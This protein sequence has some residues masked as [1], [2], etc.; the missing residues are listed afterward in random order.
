MIK[1]TSLNKIYKSKKRKLCHA[2]KD[3]DLTLADTGLVF[4]LG[5]SGSGKSTLL[6]LIGG[7]DNIT[8]GSIDVD[9]NDLS[10]LNEKAFCNYRNTHIGFIFQDYHLIDEMTVYDNIALSLN[11]LRIEAGDKVTRALEKVDLAGYEERFPSEL[12]GGERQRVAIARAIVKEPRIILADEPTG[13]LDT[14]TSKA[15][16]ELLQSI[17]KECLIIVVSH[18]V[19]EAHKYAD[20]IIELSNGRV[21]NDTMRNPDFSDEVTLENGA[22]VYPMDRLLSDEDISLI[23]ENQDKKIIKRS[24]K[25]IPTKICKKS[26]SKR[27]IENKTLSFRAKMS[28]CKKFLANKTAIIA[29]SAFMVSVIIVIMSLAQTVINFKA[30]D[31]LSKEIKK[32]E[33]D[34][35]LFVKGQGVSPTAHL[36]STKY[37]VEIG[38]N[39][40]KTFTDAGYGGKIYPVYNITVPVTSYRNRSGLVSNNI[41]QN[42]LINETLGTM[43]VTEEFLKDKFGE[44]KYI[45]KRNI[46]DPAGLIITD[47]VA[48]SI[49]S[50]HS[51]YKNKTY[52]NILGN[53]TYSGLNTA[54]LKINAIID[55]GYDERYSVLLD[56]IKNNEFTD[57]AQMYQ[58]R[59][60]VNFSNEIYDRLGFS[61]SLNENFTESFINNATVYRTASMQKLMV[62]DLLQY[63]VN[64]NNILLIARGTFTP[65]T[66]SSSRYYTDTIPD[67]PANAKYMTVSFSFST[68]TKK[69]EA[70]LESILAKKECAHIVFSNGY[71]V[72]KERLNFFEDRYLTTKGT[73]SDTGVTGTSYVS[74]F[75][76][77]PDGAYISEFCTISMRNNAHCAFYDANKKLISSFEAGKEPLPDNSISMNYNHYNDMFGT[78]YDTSSLDDFIPHKIKLTQYRLY[79]TECKYPMYSVEVTITAL[80]TGITAV[81]DNV[82]EEFAKNDVYATALYMDEEGDL[83]KVFALAESMN[84]ENQSTSIKAI[85]TMTTAVDVFVPIFRLIAIVL[86][87]GVIFILMSFSS[88]M[89]RSKMHAIGILKAL[90]TKNETIGIVFGTQV[91]LIAALTCIIATLGYYFFID[92]ANTILIKSLIRLT[93]DN[94]MLDLEFL[95][96]MPETAI[97]DCIL[98][99]ALAAISLVL[100]MIKI[101][102]IKPVKIIKT[103]E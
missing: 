67:I 10:K 15:I 54:H 87:V 44:L 21:I 78:K 99:M 77:I 73:L 32:S 92:M 9:G 84:Y 55:T 58:D 34:S 60:F 6:N 95:S 86:C 42:G 35:M 91:F 36:N 43:V 41:T 63:G 68:E 51:Q 79:D 24:D 96:F 94:I 16:T 12:S 39:D 83:G 93:P 25:Y 66:I 20:R 103:K 102:R 23:N 11:L 5:K 75:I 31:I 65:K 3:I 53:Y 57:T 74:D 28:L 71:E 76:E 62:N 18:N 38:E 33:V 88:K 64:Q 52:E 46:F 47:Y 101:K 59:D 14:A 49:L 89:I 81:S 70:Y 56:K 97:M 85:H 40:I 80:Q 90:G 27:K 82:L 37:H 72:E 48:D 7:L 13:N 61:Y 4:V 1:I 100:P 19:T 17:S 98:V 69:V 45:A 2:L 29:L 26:G 8:S 30:S 22:L 50:L